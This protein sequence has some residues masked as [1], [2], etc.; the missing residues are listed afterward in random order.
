MAL[1]AAM[2]SVAVVKSPWTIRSLSS[3]EA[4][5]VVDQDSV[6]HVTS[7]SGVRCAGHGN[8]FF[9]VGCDRASRILWHSLDIRSGRRAPKL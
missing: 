8:L 5:V 3:W 4:V 2:A 1:Q 7:I 6:S 9:L